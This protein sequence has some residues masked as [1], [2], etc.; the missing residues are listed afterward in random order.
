VS[1]APV[2]TF[3]GPRPLSR[4]EYDQMVDAGLFEDE[5]VELLYG[6]IDKMSPKG[7]D[8]DDA[9]DRL[10]ELLG[11]ALAGRARIRIQNSFAAS[12]LSEPEPDVAVVPPGDYRKAHPS[13]AWL[14]IEVSRTS[15]PKD[16]G[17]KAKLYAESNVGEYWVVNL[18]D[19]LV[20]VH[21]DI[22][23]GSYT[24]VVSYRKGETIQLLRFPDV[25][26]AV[27]DVLG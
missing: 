10:N 14:V 9:I 25:T 18:V 24:R 11:R 13:E 3:D 23:G 16:R 21:S 4:A 6:V 17:M 19:E 12:D 27:S 15:L 7:P 22:V 26:V 5:R 20:M 2:L 1:T 8:H